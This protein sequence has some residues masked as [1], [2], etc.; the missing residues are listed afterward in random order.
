[1]L[2]LTTVSSLFKHFLLLLHVVGQTLLFKEEVLFT[3]LLC[4]KAKAKYIRPDQKRS[5]QTRAWFPKINRALTSPET[6]CEQIV[7]FCSALL[8]QTEWVCGVP[9]FQMLCN[10]GTVKVGKSVLLRHNFCL[11]LKG[12]LC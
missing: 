10:I 8:M 1:M 12:H 7:L 2:F 4:Q 6:M 11:V 5:D 3:C 9:R